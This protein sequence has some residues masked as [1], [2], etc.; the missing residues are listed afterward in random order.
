MTSVQD[1]ADYIKSSLG[2]T[3]EACDY[4]TGV[5]ESKKGKYVNFLL[6]KR[7]SESREFDEISN[8]AKYSKVVNHV[9]PNGVNRIAIYLK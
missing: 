4:F 6:N 3:L 1:I 7:V 8:F 9:E 2:I 5:R